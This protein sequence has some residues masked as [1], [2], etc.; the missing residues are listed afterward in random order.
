MFL[1]KKNDD[2][3]KE[4]LKKKENNTLDFKL[5]IS[6]SAKIAK[7]L[8][9]FANTHGGKIAI[10]ISDNKKIVGIDP[11]EELY[12][13]HKAATEFCIPSI[14]YQ[15]EVFEVHYLCDEKLE[16]ELYILIIDI[17]KSDKDHCV[18]SPN[19]KLLKY[20][21]IHDQNIPKHQS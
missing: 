8:V 17:P 1:P 10:G 4:L 20:Q 15:T 19:Q 7:T 18:L 6:S 2:F 3:I 13:I 11:E 9:A 16:E 21:R 14:Q 12:M 5:N